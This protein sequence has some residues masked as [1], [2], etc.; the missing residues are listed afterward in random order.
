MWTA[1]T[2]PEGRSD[3]TACPP[4]AD[5]E[6]AQ[7]ALAEAGYPNGEGFPTL[8]LSYYQDDTVKKI[9]EAMAEMLKN[10]LN[11][12]VEV[13]SNDW[14]IFYEDVQQGNYEV[15]AMAGAPTT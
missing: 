15:A 14:A 8:K 1:R 9:V 12:N 11:I 6:A 5:V 3:P 13:S 10:N 2:S 7:A 4:T